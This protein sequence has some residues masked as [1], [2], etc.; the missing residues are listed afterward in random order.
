MLF[1]LSML[2]T[3][4]ERSQFEELYLTYRG[5]MYHVACKILNNHYDAE[6]AVHQAFISIM[7]H[8]DGISQ[9]RSPKTRSYVVIIVERKALDILKGKLRK[10]TVELNEA[11]AGIEIPMPGDGGLADAM[12]KLPPHY[13]SVLLLRYDNGFSTRNISKHL[14]ITESGVRKLLGRAKK[15]LEAELKKDVGYNL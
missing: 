12:A 2:D 5:L 4:E 3:P 7:N 9:I 6:D 13:R 8:F 10:P 11:T 1:Y 15:A 14:G